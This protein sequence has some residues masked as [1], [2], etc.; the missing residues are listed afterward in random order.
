MG[1][2]ETKP[3]RSEVFKVE[4]YEQVE[5]EPYTNVKDP[6]FESNF[7]VLS[8]KNNPG[9]QVEKYQLFFNSQAEYISYLETYYERKKYAS[10]VN[11]VHIEQT[12]KKNM[13]ST[14][15]SASVYIERIHFRLFEL[16]EIPLEE[17]LN[18]I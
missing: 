2:S 14:F 5:W 1:G 7:V 8:H 16:I 10:L 4:D 17:G 3:H 13:C 11:S 12:T 6:T 15:H 18:I 9:L